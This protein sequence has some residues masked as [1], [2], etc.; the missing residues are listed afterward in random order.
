MTKTIE[1]IRK[2]R[3]TLLNKF[4]DLKEQIAEINKAIIDLT[5]ECEHPNAY[6]R[7]LGGN[8][9]PDCGLIYS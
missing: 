9:C 5:T 8:E 2:E 3:E 7:E 1:E 6:G 4:D